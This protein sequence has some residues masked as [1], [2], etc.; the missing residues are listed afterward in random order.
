[1]ITPSLPELID[2]DQSRKEKKKKEGEKGPIFQKCLRSFR[3][4]KIF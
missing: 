4:M 1:M 3:S 2:H